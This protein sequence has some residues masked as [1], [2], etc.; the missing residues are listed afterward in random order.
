MTYYG[1]YSDAQSRATGYIYTYLN[2]TGD[3]I[4]VT[5]VSSTKKDDD[6][7]TKYFKDNMYM[8]K[9]IKYE[10]KIKVT[11]GFKMLD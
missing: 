4:E 9:L 5:E 8:D 3:K 7:M 6:E 2:A 1:Y 10:S 11:K